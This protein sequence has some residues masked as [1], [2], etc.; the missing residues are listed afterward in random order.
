MPLLPLCIS[1]KINGVLTC[2]EI[3]VIRACTINYNYRFNYYLQHRVKVGNHN[4]LQDKKFVQ[5]CKFFQL[6]EEIL[7]V[8]N[9]SNLDNKECSEYKNSW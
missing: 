2:V 9:N 4:N 7:T 8:P 1:R 6:Y 3:G 5:I